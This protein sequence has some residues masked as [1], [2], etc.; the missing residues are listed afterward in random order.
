MTE[1]LRQL[2]LRLDVDGAVTVGS[3]EPP[4][5]P[6]GA[7]ERLVAAG[8]LTRGTNETGLVCGECEEACW[9]VPDRFTRPDGEQVL[10]SGC[11][12]GNPDAGVLTFPL[13]RLV[14]WRLDVAGMASALAEA[15]SLRGT[16]TEVVPGRLWRLGTVGSGRNRRPV[17]LAPGLARLSADARRDLLDQAGP[18]LPVVLVPSEIPTDVPSDRATIVPLADVLDVEPDGL[19]LDIEAVAAPL[20]PV[21][22]DLKPVE[23]PAGTDWESIVVRVVDDEHVQVVVGRRIEV[24]SFRDLGMVDARRREPTPNATW[25]FLLALAHAGGSMTWRDDAADDNNRKRVSELR[26][27]LKA[28][29]KLHDDPFHPYATGRGWAPRFALVDLRGAA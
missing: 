12:G 3:H 5:W 21:K 6:A 14:T 7:H 15:G 26:D 11:I 13:D 25:A 22:R 24:R 23:V 8:L 28:A 1:L 17:L 20:A 10:I 18:G 27:A 19:F 4:T 2:L 29:L 16:V 9:V